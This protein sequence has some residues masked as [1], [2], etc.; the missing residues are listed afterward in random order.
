MQQKVLLQF[1]CNS[2]VTMATRELNWATTL[3]T[4]GEAFEVLGNA[5]KAQDLHVSPSPSVN[6]GSRGC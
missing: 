4:G 6:S 2:L 1:A 3:D 5:R